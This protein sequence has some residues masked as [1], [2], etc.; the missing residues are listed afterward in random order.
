VVPSEIREQAGFKP[1]DR[2]L[3]VPVEDGVI[4]KKIELDIDS[5]YE[6]L[7]QNIQKRFR[8]E[9]VDEDVVEDAI[10]WARDQKA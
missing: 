7:S 1:S 6:E 10:E 4:F 8:E 5:E 3:A 2:F 9:D